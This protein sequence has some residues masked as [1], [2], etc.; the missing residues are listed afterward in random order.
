MDPQGRRRSNHRRIASMSCAAISAFNRRICPSGCTHSAAHDSFRNKPPTGISFSTGRTATRSLDDFSDSRSLLNSELPTNPWLVANSSAL[1]PDRFHLSTHSRRCSALVRIRFLNPFRFI[2][3]SS[4]TA[5]SPGRCGWP[6]A[7]DPVAIRASQ[8]RHQTNDRSLPVCRPAAAIQ[9]DKM[10][11]DQDT[12][13]GPPGS[14]KPRPLTRDWP[15]RLIRPILCLSP[16][17]GCSLFPSS[18]AFL[19]GLPL[20]EAPTDQSAKGISA[21]SW[22]APTLWRFGIGRELDGS[23][24]LFPGSNGSKAKSGRGQPLSKTVPRV[25]EEQRRPPVWASKQAV[26]FEKTLEIGTIKTD[27]LSHRRLTSIESQELARSKDQR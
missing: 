8:S 19:G 16:G 24:S 2:P 17:K 21:R 25:T 22:T 15:T 1:S 23:R 7:Y 18:T 6:D 20:S 13:P 12:R 9:M 14:R 10:A 11:A 3:P 27:R 26:Y 4:P 5:A